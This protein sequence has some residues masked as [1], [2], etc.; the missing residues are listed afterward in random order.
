MFLIAA[1]NELEVKSIDIGNAYLNAE[2]REKCH[3]TA[4]REF[5]DRAGEPV[6]I[7]RAF[8]GIKM[9]GAAWHAHCAETLRSMRF[10]PSLADPDVW[11]RSAAKPNG[12]EYYEYLLVYVDDIL[13]ISHDPNPILQCIQKSYRLKEPAGD[14][15]IFLGAINRG[16]FQGTLEKSGA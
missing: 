16:Q 9:S 5:G 10:T 8:Y 7:V 3:T 1:L 6:L 14:P 13:I 11:Y 15:K 12:F 4:G 2:A